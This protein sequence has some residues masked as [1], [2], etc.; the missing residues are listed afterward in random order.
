MIRASDGEAVPQPYC[1]P[2]KIRSPELLASGRRT[3]VLAA[4]DL[5]ATKGFHE[6]TVDEI[7]QASGL[8]IGALYKYVR[9]KHDI[10]YLA[11]M[12][13]TEEVEA[14][15]AKWT[16]MSIP[17]RE[18]LVGAISSYMTIS[19]ERYK[20]IRIN[21]RHNHVLDVEARDYLFALENRLRDHF[22]SLLRRAAA[23]P[24]SADSIKL[25]VLADNIVVLT[26]LWS[27]SHR[28][29]AQYLS[30][31]DFTRIQTEV[32]LAAISGS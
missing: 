5:F 30:L 9:S 25:T 26:H 24:V 10:L 11:S 15:L 4:I 28:L 13:Q 16:D 22:L 3:I 7:A 23:P 6:T 12:L 31:Q 29:Y 32:V 27:V 20:T 2:S 18:A 19:D 14:E 21:Y 17:P 1:V 8:T